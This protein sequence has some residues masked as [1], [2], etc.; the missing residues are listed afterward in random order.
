[1]GDVETVRGL[2]LIELRGSG[3]DKE[4]VGSGNKADLAIAQLGSH[5]G[6]RRGPGI[7]PWPLVPCLNVFR[8]VSKTLLNSYRE[9]FTDDA[10]FDATVD[11]VPATR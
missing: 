11:P 5:S 1:M 6:L 3:C 8:A 4:R 2:R 7:E 9:A 10:I